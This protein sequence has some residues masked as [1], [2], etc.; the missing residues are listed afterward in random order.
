[1][2]AE[3]TDRYERRHDH[4]RAYK[5]EGK[6][7]IACFYGAVPKELIYAAGMIPIQLIED[8]NSQYEQKSNYLPYLCG[9]SKNIAGQIYD[10]VFDYVDGVMVSTVCDTN[11]HVYDIWKHEKLF[12][13]HW[14]VRAPSTI[15][16]A[17]MTFFTKE[18]HRLAD[19]LGQLSGQ[20]V[21]E[22]TLQESITLHNENRVL[23]QE[24]Y[25]ARLKSDISGEDAL[26]V[27]ASALVTPV[28][29]HNAMMKKLL[30]SLAPSSG[31]DQETKLMLCALN[32]NMSLDII[33]MVDRYG[34]KVVTDDFTHNAR[35]GSNMIEANGDPFRALAKGYLRKIPVP[36]VFSIEDRA[37][38]IRELMKKADAKGMIYLIQLYC[39]AYSLEYGVLKPRFDEW[40]LPHL[41]IEAE[42]TPSSIEQLNVRVQSFLESLF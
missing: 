7:I 16:E 4:A 25:D 11:R 38:Y 42:D 26:Q 29:E 14:L 40:N 3:F 1:M 20:K 19:E 5:K 28:D 27:F 24:F 30:S 31:G 9:L 35:Y 13:H 33:K 2:I 37:I 12:A 6:K 15:S 10:N 23:F 36:G 21:T 18:L 22:E 32:F 17:S 8:R 41:K 34:G 39:D